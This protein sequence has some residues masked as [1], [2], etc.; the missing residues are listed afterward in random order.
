ME[1][2]NPPQ[3]E[4][5]AQT[6]CGDS[7]QEDAMAK[8]KSVRKPARK[9]AKKPSS[10]RR[11]VRAKAPSRKP[12]VPKVRPGLITHTELASSSP[13]ATRAWCEKVLGWKFGEPMQSPAGPYHMWRFD[14]AT[15]G[16][17]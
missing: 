11:P 4:M 7:E 6:S 8:R 13:P 2:Q 14:N 17:I 9:V 5:P 12:A 1:P 15:G 16:G 10:K 3:P